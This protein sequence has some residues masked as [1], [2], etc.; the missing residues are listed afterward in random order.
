MSTRFGI[1]SVV[2][3]AVGVGLAAVVALSGCASGQRQSVSSDVT[4]YSRWPAQRQPGTYEF[5]TL[6][7]AAATSAQQ[8]Q[9]QE[10]ARA[11]IERAGFVPVPA[12]KTA[13]FRIQLGL[14][15]TDVARSS[16]FDDPFW[17][18]GTRL[19]SGRGLPGSWPGWPSMIDPYPDGLD[20]QREVAVLIRASD[21]SQVMFEAQASNDDAVFTASRALPA[22]FSAALTDFPGG[23]SK[24]HRIVV[25]TYVAPR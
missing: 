17:Y 4:S 7:S 19:R 11:A 1:R 3:V 8:R 16:P 22:M 23:N 21:S 15:L 12:G 14:R 2:A 9:L 20:R 18:A 6:P 5:E 24:M 13:D 25:D 10:A